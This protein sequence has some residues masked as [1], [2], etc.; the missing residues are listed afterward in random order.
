MSQIIFNVGGRLFETGRNT[1]LSIPDSLLATMLCDVQQ[2]PL[3]PIFIDRDPDV[4]AIVLNL[5]RH[6]RLVNHNNIESEFLRSELEFYGLDEYV[7]KLTP[8]MPAEVAKSIEQ[9]NVQTTFI[10]EE[11]HRVRSDKR[12]PNW[13]YVWGIITNY[14][15]QTPTYNGVPIVDREYMWGIIRQVNGIRNQKGYY[16]EQEVTEGIEAILD[17]WKERIVTIERYY[18]PYM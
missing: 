9:L 14:C 1:I 8:S 16:S 13:G 3:E 12:M 15:Y 17:H 5:Y 11:L 6:K 7:H 10:A 4:F 2:A 18:T